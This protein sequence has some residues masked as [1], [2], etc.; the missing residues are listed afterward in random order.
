MQDWSFSG[1]G[2]LLAPE[3]RLNA[4]NRNKLHETVI[5]LDNFSQLPQP[6]MPLA[7]ADA[8]RWLQE[9]LA[10]NFG[11]PNTFV[12]RGFEA[13]ARLLHPV[14]RDRPKAP[15]TWETISAA[16]PMEFEQEL[17]SWKTVA[18][19]QGRQVHKYTQGTSLNP[20]DVQSPI[21]QWFDNHGWRYSQ[22]VEGN[23]DV[24]TLGH[25][26]AVLAQYTGTPRR[27]V[28]AVW[29]GWG[30]G[31]PV[32]YSSSKPTGWDTAVAAGAHAAR[33][34]KRLFTGP[35]VRLELPGRSHKLFAAGVLEFVTPDW[36]ARAPWVDNVWNEQS[37]S[38][39]WP[40]DHTWVLATEVDY[41]STIIAG[42]KELIEALLITEEL[43][44]FEIASDI[45]E[46]LLIYPD[47]EP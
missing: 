33:N 25:V 30:S 26:A 3:S 45:E 18:E 9:R 12:P 38:I 21:Q 35:E 32:R 2:I 44:V 23:L 31:I 24:D 19:T 10:K 17:V 42:S 46:R 37:P 8:G 13:Y 20:N 5:L 15:K 6:V 43:E 22:T 47:Q 1:A 40:E 7:S 4:S 36:V 41:D 14:E 29:E 39:L 11:E 34:F 16:E 28:A 27:G